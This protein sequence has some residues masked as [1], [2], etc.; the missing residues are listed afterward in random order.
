MNL[1]ASFAVNNALWL[2]WYR[3][4]VNQPEVIVDNGVS[5]VLKLIAF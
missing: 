5:K 4:V 3:V 1:F 2:L